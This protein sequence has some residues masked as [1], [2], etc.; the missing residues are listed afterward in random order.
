MSRRALAAPLLLAVM[1][2]AACGGAGDEEAP[3]AA[4]AVPTITA[5]S[6]PIATFTEDTGKPA[7]TGA[8]KPTVAP[9]VVVPSTTDVRSE[10]VLAGGWEARVVSALREVDPR[11]VA[12]QP[13]A[14]KKVRA[15]CV[16][17]ESGMFSTKVIPIIEKRFSS[18]K[19]SVSAALA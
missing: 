5:S 11:L 3:A 1:L 12:D 2:T 8:G 7:K 19:F 17:M 14:V 15:T 9:E 10:Q 18:R 6:V 16:Q 4:T 13:A